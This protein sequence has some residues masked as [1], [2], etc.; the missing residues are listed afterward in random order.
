MNQDLK[1]AYKIGGLTAA[2][3]MTGS[4]VLGGLVMLLGL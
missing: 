3:I 2:A 1:Q 4:I